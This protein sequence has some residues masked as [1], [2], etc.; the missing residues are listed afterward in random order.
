[1][2]PVEIIRKKRNG[3]ALTRGELEFLIRGYLDGS[4]KEYQMSAFLMSVYFRGMGFDETSIL[5]DV[6]LRTGTIVETFDP[7][8][9]LTTISAA[10]ISKPAPAVLAVEAPAGAHEPAHVHRE[11]H[12]HG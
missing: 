2:N 1:M 4:V 9:P 3:G 7:L 12:G 6:M 11:A 10:S 8:A 5:T